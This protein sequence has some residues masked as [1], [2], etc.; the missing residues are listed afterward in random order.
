M[1]NAIQIPVY[2]LTLF[3]SA[4]LLFSV[5]PIMGKIL[6]PLLGGTPAVWNTAMLFFQLML[7]AGYAWAHIAARFFSV[8]VQTIVQLGLMLAAMATLPISLHG[9]AEPPSGASPIGWQLGV[10]L[11]AVGAPFF[12][13]AATAP[14]LQ[15]WFAASGHAQAHNP[16]FLYA[17][18]N[19]GSMVALLIYPFAVEPLLDLGRQT[20]LWADGFAALMG[21]IA[22]SGL[23]LWLHKP[24]NPDEAVAHA[25]P[26]PLSWRERGMWVLLAFI[27][28]SLMLGVTTA[29]TTDIASV[30]LLWIIPLALYLAT[31]IFAFARR[32]PISYDVALWGM[33]IFLA[34]VLAVTMA[35]KNMNPFLALF[36][37]CTLFF[38]T[39]LA[40]HLRLASLQPHA[41]HLTEY[42][43]LISVGGA[44]GGI[45]NG[46]IAPTVF[47]TPAEYTLVLLLACFLRKPG[48]NPGKLIPDKWED[49]FFV[50]VL[51]GLYVGAILMT[52]YAQYN[53]RFSFSILAGLLV[54][55]SLFYTH[56]RPWMFVVVAGLPLLLYPGL[57]PN[58]TGKVLHQ[59][60]N[61]FGILKVIDDTEDNARGLVHG[62]TLHGMQSLDPKYKN[63]PMSYYHPR[64][65]IANVFKV[66]GERKGPQKIAVV[67]LG[68]GGL[69]AYLRP[70]WTFD[71]YEIDPAVV[72]IAKDPKY[73]TFLE[74]CGAAC[75][76]IVGDGRLEIAKAPD[77]S[78]DLIFLDVF[79]SDNIPPHIITK[80]AFSIYLGKLKPDGLMAAHLSSRYLDLAPVAGASARDNGLA[81]LTRFSPGGKENDTQLFYAATIVTAF[82]RTEKELDPFRKIKGWGEIPIPDGFRTW[83]D[84][85]TNVVAAFRRSTPVLEIPEEDIGESTEAGRAKGVGSGKPD[86][87]KGE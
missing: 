80:E 82:A 47:K 66:M 3:M 85:Y 11:A 40:C 53:P 37:H 70:G 45:L 68:T 55:V 77:E 59:S 4:L 65:S 48:G 57:G 39:A 50:F 25:P 19:A 43:L 13:L 62:T 10:M 86:P 35:G 49:R 5:Q 23:F 79:S 60:R 21:L 31:F 34:A 6:L 46:L 14:M 84:S 51:I 69:S 26:T 58:V 73:F 8:R 9:T 33:T 22:L 41:D 20:P 76:V 1:K 52:L 18:S 38:F 27:P 30:P 81:G 28:S 72:E 36:M 74:T 12:V 42:Y 24:V 32:K 83:T 56:A 63:T 44:L 2:T 54:F 16:Y 61:F 29:I 78:Y 17:A 64:T 15:R 75:S 87:V 67:G 71:F 7:L